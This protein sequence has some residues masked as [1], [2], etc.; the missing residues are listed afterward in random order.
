MSKI[1]V[2]CIPSDASGVGKFRSVDPHVM[3]DKNHGDEF[4]VDIDYNPKINDIN[5]WKQYDIVHFHRSIGHDYNIATQIITNLNNLGIVTIMDLD[6]YWLPTREHP[7]HQLVLQ[8]K[9]HEAIIN[10]LKLA[11]Y[12]TTTTSVFADEIKKYNKNVFVLPNAINPNEPQFQATTEPSDK[13][14]F[15]WLGGSC[16]DDITEVL[17]ENGF[18]LFKDLI[19]GERVATLNPA[20]NEIEYH[21]PKNY[22]TE[23][24][25]GELNCVNNGLIDYAVTPNHKMY[26]STIKH[27][28]RKN[29]NFK[30]IPSE[31][32]HNT[33]F[34]VKRDGI[35]NGE[36]R[37]YFTLPAYQNTN[38]TDMQP[39]IDMF[40]GTNL[41]NET[42]LL[43]EYEGCVGVGT[44]QNKEQIVRLRR[45]TKDNFYLTT[46]NYLIN[47][48]GEERQLNMDEWL[49]FFGFWLAEGWVTKTNGLYQVGVCQTKDNGYLEEMF[50]TLKNMGFEPTYTKD[51]KQIRVFDKQLWQYLYQFG[52]CD[53]KFIPN[54]L[55]NLPSRQLNILLDWFIK[56]DGHVEEN[57]GRSR[58]WTTSKK[59]SDNLQEIA[60]KTGVAATIT[61]CDKKTTQIKGMEIKSIRDSYM[62]GFSKHPS[63]SKHNKLTPLVRDT[64]QFKREYDGMVYCVEVENHILYVRRNGKPFWCGNSH[65]HDLKLLEGTFNKLSNYTDKYSLY[66]CG[67]DLRGNVTEVNKE[68]G[69]QRQ[70]PI[71]PEETVWARYEEIFTNN[72]KLIEPEHKD[73]LM[74]FKEGEFHSDELPFYN[75]VWTKPVTSYATNYRLFDVSLAPIKNHIFN[76]VKSQLKVIEA[77]FYKKAIIASNIGPYTIDL[78]HSLKNGEFVDGNALL[79]DEN[80]NHSDW[81]KYM[82]KLIENPNWAYDLGQRLYE[83]VKDTYDLNKVTSDRAQLYKSLIK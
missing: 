51:G 40:S 78:K 33:H 79:V 75:R 69:E 55:L 38:T 37:E 36:E 52:G 44:Y 71:K 76:R 49:K 32:V 15:G 64:H 20:T 21:V 22:I 34:H 18:K 83:T 45:S 59:L 12:V 54:E 77:G 39:I 74:K 29:I 61:L 42:E 17:T 8:H 14:R 80:K 13:L 82:K 35:W 47:K 26:V 5:Y 7:V 50:N 58:A 31:E 1:R 2:L 70:R 57:Y 81:A 43:L 25:K 30:L 11:R 41:L 53:T 48:Y 27:L 4:H 68:T 6:D 65:L 16:Y 23:P 19:E 28:G 56:G 62:L 73:F 67:F 60:L 63:V 66:L 9:I 24:F 3:L 46:E 72:Y 10:N